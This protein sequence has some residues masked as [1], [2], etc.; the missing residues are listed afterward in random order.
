MAFQVNTVKPS[1]MMLFISPGAPPS[2]PHPHVPSLPFY[3]CLPLGTCFHAAG[4]NEGFRAAAAKQQ[5]AGS[6]FQGFA[7]IQK[8]VEKREGTGNNTN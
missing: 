8:W 1:P 6:L 5:D 3:Q 4:C 7:R 2:A